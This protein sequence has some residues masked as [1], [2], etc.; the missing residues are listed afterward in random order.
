MPARM[1]LALVIRL[2]PAVAPAPTPTPTATAE[3]APT[4]AVPS[5][6]AFE[7]IAPDGCPDATFARASVEHYAGRSLADTAAVLH[8]ARAEIVAQAQGD[9]RLRLELEV[10]AGTP[11]QRTLRDE[12]CRV[13]AETA[14]LMIAVTI[15]PLAATRVGTLP[16]PAPT[17]APTP[18]PPPVEPPKPPATKPSTPPGPPTRSCDAGPALRRT[19]VTDRRPCVGLEARA[20]LQLGLL[21]TAIGPGVAI[22]LAL[23]WPRLRIELGG[24][25]WF[26]RPAR[27]GDDRNRGGD[28]QLSAGSLGACARLRHR[29]HEFPLCGGAEVGALVGRGV[30]IAVPRREQLLWLAA[31]AGPRWMWS[32]HRRVALLAD[33]DVVVPM[34]R[35]RFEVGGL[36]VVHRVDP[37]GGRVHLG[38]GIRL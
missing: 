38:L 30:G 25:H 23:A 36:G 31:W 32:V 26:R 11:V 1:A 7:W 20:G 33:V 3:G 4:S 14:A 28:L 12:S 9:F 18:E 6:T 15:D 24:S 19:G 21:P 29:A 34:A 16:E 10:A 8:A 35:Y 22:T 17:R 5:P 27:T 37:V 2:A 13:L